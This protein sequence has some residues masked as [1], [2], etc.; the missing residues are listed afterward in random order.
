[1]DDDQ[2]AGFTGDLN[3][4]ADPDAEALKA[5]AAHMGWDTVPVPPRG[6]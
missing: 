5:L 3:A 2:R 6:G 1:M 4:P